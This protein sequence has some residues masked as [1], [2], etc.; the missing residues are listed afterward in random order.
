MNMLII[1]KNKQ[2]NKSPFYWR[3]WIFWKRNLLK[4]LC[5]MKLFWYTVLVEVDKT[6]SEMENLFFTAF[7]SSE[8]FL[9]L[10]ILWVR[11]KENEGRNNACNSSELCRWNK[12][13]KDRMS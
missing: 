11:V 4:S 9:K 2:T 1:I 6:F 3:V 13:N 10:T 12:Y 5:N 8:T 7:A